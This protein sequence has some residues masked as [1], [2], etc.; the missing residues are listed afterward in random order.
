MEQ[1]AQGG[2][3][4]A[5]TLPP[6]GV[7][8]HGDPDTQSLM[9]GAVA[10]GNLFTLAVLRGKAAL[11]KDP[12]LEGNTPPVL[13]VLPRLGAVIFVITSFYFLGLAWSSAAKNGAQTQASGAD[14]DLKL[15][16]LANLLGTAAVLMRT[17]V[18]FRSPPLSALTAEALEV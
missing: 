14:A 1:I 6:I 8:L 3:T 10:A 7:S 15:I 18:I 5:V 9:T 4:M 12:S 2:E 13:D 17:R 11:K 16:L